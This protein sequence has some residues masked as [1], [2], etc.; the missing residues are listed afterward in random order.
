MVGTGQA[1]LKYLKNCVCQLLLSCRFSQSKKEKFFISFDLIL[2]TFKQNLRFNILI[3]S[4]LA[5]KICSLYYNQWDSDL[6]WQFWS[7][8]GFK[9][10]SKSTFENGCEIQSFSKKLDLRSGF[11]IPDF[12]SWKV[13]K[14]LNSQ[15]N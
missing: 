4:T 14:I 9:S 1:L 12:K 3:L 10:R 15:E 6:I 11:S 13:C 2:Q 8:F 7:K 5:F